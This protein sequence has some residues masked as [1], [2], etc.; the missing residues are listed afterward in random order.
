MT[1]RLLSITFPLGGDRSKN[2]ASVTFQKPLP[3][4]ATI[5]LSRASYF[6]HQ[7]KNTLNPPIKNIKKCPKMS[8]GPPGESLNPDQADN[9][10]EV[11]FLFMIP[12]I[13]VL[14]SRS[15]D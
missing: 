9:F 10:E 5:L 7:D 14:T 8:L 3:R 11:R 13:V 12:D 2:E 4:G 6:L 1:E 15:P